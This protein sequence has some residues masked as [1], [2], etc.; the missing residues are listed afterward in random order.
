[1]DT[2]GERSS[3][4]AAACPAPPWSLAKEDAS[5]FVFAIWVVFR[6]FETRF[7]AYLMQ[8]TDVEGVELILVSCPDGDPLLDGLLA[9]ALTLDQTLPATNPAG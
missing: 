6:E 4:N 2:G 9:P 5:A 8:G 1:M 7:N 3:S